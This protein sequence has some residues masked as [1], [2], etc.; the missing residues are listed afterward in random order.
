MEKEKIQDF[1]VRITNANKTGMITILY[2]IGITYIDDALKS[3]EYGDKVGFRRE[4]PRIRATL[5]E[6]QNSLNT[7]TEA[8][9]VLLKLYVFLSREIS[10]SFMDYSAEPL[11]HVRKTFEKLAAS[12]REAEKKDMTGPVMEHTEPVYAGFTYNRNSLSEDFTG[13]ELNRGFL[14]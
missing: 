3:L 5:Q 7:G 1:T 12:Y 13:R 11:L 6:L 14:V 9:K 2:E 4:I 10:Q 8:G